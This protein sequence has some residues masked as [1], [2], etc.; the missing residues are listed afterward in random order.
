MFSMFVSSFLKCSGA[1]VKK[2]GLLQFFNDVLTPLD[3]D[4]DDSNLATPGK[5]ESQKRNS[6][7]IQRIYEL[8]YEVYATAPATLHSV[9]PL[10]E[11][12]L[13]VFDSVHNFKINTHCA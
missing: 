13:K 2:S 6:L 10:L 11:I 12:K 1:S 8:L 3:A 7:T 4:D 5:S 9:L